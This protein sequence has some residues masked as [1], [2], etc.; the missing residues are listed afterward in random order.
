MQES[1]EA[2]TWSEALEAREAEQLSN[3]DALESHKWEIVNK[4]QRL[5]HQVAMERAGKDGHEP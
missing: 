3:V 5:E 1:E 4:N 2:K